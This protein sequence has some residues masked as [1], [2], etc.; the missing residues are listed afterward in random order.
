MADRV[1]PPWHPTG[2]A[3]WEAIDD[4]RVSQSGEDGCRPSPH[5]LTASIKGRG[6]RSF[7]RRDGRRES[8]RGSPLLAGLPL[9]PHDASSAL[10]DAAGTANEQL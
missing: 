7:N 9:R 4:R 2:Y 10:G 6:R 1:L 8:G 5:G 3:G